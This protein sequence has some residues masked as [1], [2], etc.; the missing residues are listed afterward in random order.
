MTLIP[1][2]YKSTPSPPLAEI[3]ADLKQVEEEILRL[4]REVTE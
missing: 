3:D 1:K 4:L 2:R